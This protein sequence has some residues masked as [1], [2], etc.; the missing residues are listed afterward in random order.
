MDLFEELEEIEEFPKNTKN[1]GLK[2]S[3]TCVK[4]FYNNEDDIENLNLSCQD[5][6]WNGGKGS[7]YKPSDMN[8]YINKYFSNKNE[9]FNNRSP[10]VYPKEYINKNMDEICNISDYTL[11]PQQKF[12]GMFINDYTD[13]NGIL[14]MHQLGSGKT[15]TSLIIAETM[16]HLDI[17]DEELKDIEEKNVIL[18]V[19]KNVQEQ[20]YEEITGRIVDEN[21]Q[22]CVSGCIINGKR[23]Y[24]FDTKNKSINKIKQL[25]N[26]V[27]FIMKDITSSNISKEKKVELVSKKKDLEKEIKKLNDALKNKIDLVYTIVSHDK[28]LNS[29][30][31]SS[32]TGF[33]HTMIPK[34]ELIN[35]DIYHRKNSLLIIDEIQK[36]ASEYT[37]EKGS[38]YRKLYYSLNFFIRSLK[39]FEPA[40]KVVLTTATPVYDNPHEAALI[41]NLLRPRIQFPLR[42][43]VFKSMFVDNETNTMKNKLLFK[44]M[45]S[46][47]V[48]YF[49]GGSPNGY[50]Y[51][52]NIIKLHN[53]NNEQLKLYK[54]NI[55]HELKQIEE[56]VSGVERFDDLIETNIGNF[57][58]S[59]QMCNITYPKDKSN[60]DLFNTDIE[61]RNFSAKLKYLAENNNINDMLDYASAYS[62]KLTSVIKSAV[63]SDGPVFIYTGWVKHGIIGLVSILNALGWSFLGSDKLVDYKTYSI[64][65]PGGLINIGM[66]SG[67]EKY[68]VQ[69]Q[70]QESFIAKMRSIYN[71]PE[72][73]DGKRCKIVISNVVEGISLKRVRQVHVCEPWWNFSKMEQIIARGIRFCSHSDLEIDRRSVDV[74]YHACI[75]ANYSQNVKSKNYA[76]SLDNFITTDQYMYM[77]SE[78]KN[79]LNNEFELALKESSIDCNLNKDGNVTR[80]ERVV[81]DSNTSDLY[82]KELYYD[83]GYNKYYLYENNKI[84]GIDVGTVLNGNKVYGVNKLVSWPI[85]CYKYNGED[86]TQKVSISDS[87]LRDFN[88]AKTILSPENIVCDISNMYTANLDFVRL[89]DYAMKKGE[90]QKTWE[91]AYDFLRKNYLTEYFVKNY[92]IISSDV[93]TKRMHMFVYNMLAKSLK[94]GI[95]K[96][97]SNILTLLLFGKN[98]DNDTRMQNYKSFLDKKGY[99]PETLRNLTYP[100]LEM[101]YVYEKSNKSSIKQ[102]KS[103]IKQELNIKQQKP[104]KP[105]PPNDPKA[106]NPEYVC[107][108][109]TGKWVTKKYMQTLLRKKSK[110]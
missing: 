26:Q 17:D 92:N 60:I 41:I 106:L 62:N 87:K 96:R 24:Y 102:Q 65:S 68:S 86:I 28:F 18:V 4:Y 93:T 40:M 7:D 73:R 37:A 58:A 101:L 61:I 78:K 88:D 30:C 21:F 107:N 3:K 84:I 66:V 85:T 5:R 52:R 39:T 25:E 14:L 46:G 105:C 8:D 77:K 56:K 51:R 32:D 36:L 42:K 22:S 91:I 71:S 74:Y 20:Y 11:K 49:K 63:K 12:A 95:N 72:N 55:K 100:A 2:K 80:F 57:T 109:A 94:L 70:D 98:N 83:R 53:I 104:N 47:Y 13:F 31:S 82:N 9:Q 23:Q 44:Y 45:C 99:N 64:W 76:D 29:I 19:P 6:P 27:R 89:Y 67:L 108:P 10:F 33:V 50:A 110:K 34:N 1:M 59:R 54:L 16:K 90:E 97:V 69:Q 103:N 35:K 79:M 15:C 81:I 48:S 43:D 75:Y 38:N